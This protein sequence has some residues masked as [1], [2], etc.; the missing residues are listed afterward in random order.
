M[1]YEKYQEAPS[2]NPMA[3]VETGQKA[4]KEAQQVVDVLRTYQGQIVQRDQNRVQDSANSQDVQALKS[5]GE[6]S[7]TAAGLAKTIGQQ[8]AKN[9]EIGAQFD[10]I[11]NPT[12]SPE[13]QAVYD[14]ARAQQA[15]A[16][17]AANQLEASGD[18]IGA[19]NL[20][21]D[22]GKLSQGV[23][24]EKALL[25]R[26]R[27]NYAGDVLQI[28]NGDDGLSQL[29]ATDPGAAMEIA[30]KI[31]IEENGLQYTSKNAF[32]D[33][34]GGTIRN[35]IQNTTTSQATALIK[36]RKDERLA[37]QDAITS[38]EVSDFL[39]RDDVGNT[40][41]YQE[42]AEDYKNDN[43]GVLTQGAAN[44]KAATTLL[45]SAANSGN[46][47]LV[48]A[49]GR[50]LVR[51]DQA[52]TQISS[53][54]PAEYAKALDLAEKA[55]YDN[56]IARRRQI[57]MD[58]GQRLNQL[59]PDDQAG[60]DQA[61]ADANAAY[62]DDWQGRIQFQNQYGV[63]QADPDQ[64][65]T[66][67]GLLEDIAGGQAYSPEAIRTLQ[68]ERQITQKQADSLISQSNKLVKR[69][70][71][72][73]KVYIDS[74]QDRITT[75][76]RSVTGLTQDPSTYQ[77]IPGTGP[78][79]ITAREAT[80]ISAAY[81]QDLS[82]YVRTWLEQANVGEMSPREKADLVQQKT[83]E[84]YQKEA[85]DPSGKYYL[86]GLF[87]QT[88]KVDADSDEFNAIKAD[89]K[90]F[91]RQPQRQTTGVNDFS[92]DWKPS[93]GYMAL[94]NEYQPGD[95]V[96]DFSESKGLSASV[97]E[98][99]VPTDVGQLAQGLGV[100]PIDLLKD[101]VEGGYS[102]PLNIP[103]DSTVGEVVQV[104]A[105]W[106][107]YQEKNRKYYA[108]L[109]PLVIAQGYTPQGAAA[110]I[111]MLR[112]YTVAQYQVVDAKGNPTGRINTAIAT[113]GDGRNPFDKAISR[114]NKI[115][116]ADPIFSTP[117]TTTRQLNNKIN[118]G[119]NYS[120][121]GFDFAPEIQKILELN[122]Y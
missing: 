19:E 76:I 103:G 105:G 37:E 25:Y 94:K 45:N 109:L 40:V 78:T 32:I 110:L 91:G 20:R 6:F 52:G 119:N 41:R 104:P 83:D 71:D 67:N 33:I 15:T 68:A 47:D 55:R 96:Y 11:Y 18:D 73:G 114:I 116:Q 106:K 75:K 23:A 79:P 111:S 14:A 60:R 54:Y 61:L 82:N 113:D 70:M 3:I 2:F 44:R 108:R 99:G 35:V 13:E 42:L 49:V 59:D 74:G 120:R 17:E 117:G 89:A 62:G 43:N 34:L 84:F 10:A 30:T 58:L 98:A 81:K 51:P 9:K 121:Y 118:S 31:F 5:L 12:F 115:G 66:Y 107:P 63:L 48:A 27:Q 101:S 1:A 92:G 97:S 22:M 50:A 72:L 46:V 122:G 39:T 90:F 21:Q 69:T 95:I 65:L 28:V 93:Q 85:L 88:K 4:A 86:G 8:D 36:E 77:F 53:T 112:V 16:G 38:A 100:L 26:A 56:Q 102:L 87:T 64:I 29:F 57:I 24:D 7:K 80:D